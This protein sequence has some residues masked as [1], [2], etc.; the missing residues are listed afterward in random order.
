MIADEGRLQDG[1]LIVSNILSYTR[2]R[3]GAFQL[4]GK[5]KPIIMQ[6]PFFE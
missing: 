6:M 5:N 3:A 4:G 2:V 1:D